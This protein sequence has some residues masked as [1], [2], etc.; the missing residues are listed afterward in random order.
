MIRNIAGG[1]GGGGGGG[2]SDWV[3]QPVLT[4]WRWTVSQ[5]FVMEMC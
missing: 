1:G 2:G 4:G 5:L 3:R